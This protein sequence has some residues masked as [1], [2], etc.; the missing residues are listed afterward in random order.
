MLMAGD[1]KMFIV[2]DDDHFR[3]TFIDVMSLK[4]VEVTGARNGDEAIRA[5]KQAY[6]SL[7]IMDVQLPDMHGFD[8]CR[9]VKRLEGHRDTPV[10]FVSASTQYSDPRDRAEGLLA[11]ASQFLPKPI[12]V[13]KLWSEIERV[14]Q[15]RRPS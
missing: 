8:L 1:S 13:E 14:L 4:G 11:G 9:R 3:E 6:P 12:S 2:E 5:L 10:I 15:T 7:I